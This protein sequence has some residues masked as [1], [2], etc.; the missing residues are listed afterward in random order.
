MVLST[1]GYFR[2]S[3]L[4]CLHGKILLLIPVIRSAYIGLIVDVF[5][6][7]QSA[8]GLNH[9]VW[10][11]VTN[12]LAILSIM[13]HLWL[14]TDVTYLTCL[15]CC[16]VFAVVFAVTLY[17]LYQYMY[18]YPFLMTVISMF[19]FYPIVIFV[20]SFKAIEVFNKEVLH[21]QESYRHKEV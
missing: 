2:L 5:N 8:N 20:A 6:D 4:I 9:S 21:E 1:I 7:A 16:I 18:R 19:G 17:M 12:I 3:S 10:L 15:G 13:L 11:A 14:K